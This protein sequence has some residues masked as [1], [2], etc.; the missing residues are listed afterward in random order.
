MSTQQNKSMLKRIISELN[1]GN[2][3]VIDELFAEDFVDRYPAPGETPNKEGF[4]EYQAGI[5]KSFPD[6][7]VSLEDIIGEGDK[8]AYRVTIQ[9]TDT[10]GSMG[11]PPTGKEV[12]FAA[13]GIL[14]FANGK[15]VERWTIFDSMAPLH[16]LG[17]L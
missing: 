3:N 13:I 5:P 9:G 16:Q 8:V 7:H 14:R 4:K 1:K 17:L 6:M 10:G 15:V 2:L 12:N 11:M